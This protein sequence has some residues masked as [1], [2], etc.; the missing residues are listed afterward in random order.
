MAEYLF[1]SMLNTRFSPEDSIKKYEVKSRSLS[2]QY[3][4][5]NSP[6]SAQ[7]IQVNLNKN[8]RLFYL[9]VFTIKFL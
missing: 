8:F 5:P 4:L 1:R 2:T 9:T 7:G 3:E 6:A